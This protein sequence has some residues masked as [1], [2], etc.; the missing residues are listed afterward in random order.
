MKKD[1]S[2]LLIAVTSLFVIFV[3]GFYIGRNTAP[4]PVQI[5]SPKE[6]QE[7]FTVDSGTDRNSRLNINTATKDELQALPGIG[8]VLADRII[9]F[10]EEHGNFTSISQLTQVEGIGQERLITILEY[11]IAEESH[12]NTDR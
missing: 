2:L 8:P 4:E 11:I 3:I 9:A 12:E 6:D 7:D 5:Q 1:N 10:R